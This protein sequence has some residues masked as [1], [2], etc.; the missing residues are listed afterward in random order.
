MKLKARLSSIVVAL[1]ATLATLSPSLPAAAQG[2]MVPPT[3]CFDLPV[4]LPEPLP[5]P[6]S[7]ATAPGAAPIA[8][9]APSI[10]IPRP[11]PTVSPPPR[12][13]PPPRPISPCWL[14]IRSHT[15]TVDIQDQVATTRIDQIF[16][17]ETGRDLEGTYVFPLPEGATVTSFSMF[18]DDQQITGEVLSREEARR[19]YE[20]IVRANRDPALLEFAD[21]GAFQA[22]V[23]PVPAGGKRTLR[24]EY[25]QVLPQDGG[26]VRYVYPTAAERF[27]ARPPQETSITVSLRSTA[28]LRAV[29]SPTHEVNVT[30]SGGTSATATWSS[31]TTPAQAGVRRSFELV[32]GVSPSPV[33]ISVVTHKLANEDGYFLLL[34]APALQLASER[35]VPKD[36]SLIFDTSGSMAGAKIDQAKGA[37]R[38]VV[39]R[40]NA[41]DRFNIISFSSTVDTFASGMRP[42]SERDRAIAYVD[43]L[44]ASGGTNINDA[45]FTALRADTG[46][47]PHTVIFV[48]DGLPTAGPQQ[49]DQIVENA[50]RAL[51][52]GAVRPRL[53]SFGVGFD[54]NTTLLDKLAADFGG[55]SAYVRPDEDLEAAVSTFYGKVSSPVLTDLRLD[56]GGAEVYDLY[57]SQ[58]PDLY[59]GG[60]LVLTGRYRR[61]GTIDVTLSGSAAGRPQQFTLPGVTFASAP[62][63]AQEAL[64]RLWAGRKIGY[65]LSEIRLR[66]ANKELVDEVIALATRHGIPTPYT[67]IFVPEPTV[68]VA[69]QRPGA[70][71]TAPLPQPTQAP[72]NTQQGRAQAADALSQ[73][74]RSAPAAGASAVQN[75]QA[76]NQLREAQS[77]PTSNSSG[78]QTVA[79]KTF[80]LVDS[81]WQDVSTGADAP[82]A[83]QRTRVPF[84]S[85]A[86]FELV[87][88]FPNA[89]AYLS[90]GPRVLLELE[91]SWYEITEA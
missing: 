6:A 24:L 43:G 79:D 63:K 1:A 85:E 35:A 80:L 27:S 67:S 76:T 25:S 88:R 81:V 82:P 52:A 20:S 90:V 19:L 29:Y 16:V 2:M 51:G 12:I 53:F 60:Q 13:A 72:L 73:G 32:Y 61:P 7:D 64:P 75:S 39:N 59:A 78:V 40:L 5:L 22:R 44:V 71:T 26:L 23:F 86:Y 9:V 56:F 58:L 47:R 84:A 41:E 38:Y 65:L 68:P 17:N 89:G 70:P 30:R 18:V 77:A 4:P 87:D 54:V 91:D 66:G 21:R 83:E 33:G 62:V 55:A 3:R 45:L 48:T 10:G 8:P 50:R 36:V 34:A 57:P 15:V 14:T 31:R 69:P 46:G 42:A 11:L 49:P 74:L 37:L 28:P